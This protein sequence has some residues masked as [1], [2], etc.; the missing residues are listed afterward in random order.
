MSNVKQKQLPL[1]IGLNF[2]LPGTG[3]MYMGKWIVGIFA[4]LLIT[5]IVLSVRMNMALPTWLGINIIMAIDMYMLFK[6]NESKYIENNSKKC[7]NCA[8]QIQKEAKVC[9]FCNS[10]VETT[11]A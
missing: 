2:L 3:Y 7:P 1:A 11:T 5:A 6:R 10:N 4:M 8:E 9:R